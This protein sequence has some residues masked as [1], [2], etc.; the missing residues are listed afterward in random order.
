MQAYN[1]PLSYLLNVKY[2]LFQLTKLIRLLMKIIMKTFALCFL[3]FPT[4]HLT[5]AF[6]TPQ[7]A[8]S[9]FTP[10][11]FSRLWCFHLSTI[12]T[13]LVFSSQYNFHAFPVFTS[14]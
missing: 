9:V 7:Y 6:F 8:F 12:S 2:F 10:V 11:Q 5:Y 3:I 13:P 1:L 14:V 4:S